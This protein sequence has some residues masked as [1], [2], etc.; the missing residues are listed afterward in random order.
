MDTRTRLSWLIFGMTDA[1]LFGIG[2]V[3]VLANKSLSEQ[4]AVLIPLVVI[5]SFALA[6][7]I[8]WRVE[9]GMSDAV[10]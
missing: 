3:V 2:I 8:A 4:A 7:P 10:R 6:F 5:L 9:H 1:G